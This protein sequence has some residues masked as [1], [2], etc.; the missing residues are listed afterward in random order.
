[1]E[2]KKGIVYSYR[3][4]AGSAP[5][6]FFVTV[7][8][9]PD[10]QNHYMFS[11][12]MKAGHVERTLCESIL[13]RLSID[14]TKL[15]FSVFVFPPKS[16]L[17]YGCLQNLR[18]WLRTAG[19]DHRIFADNDLWVGKDPDFRSIGDASFAVLRNATEDMLIYQGMVG[20]A[21]VS[22]IVRWNLVSVG[23][24]SLS[25]E[26]EAGGAGRPL[27]EDYRLRLDCEPQTVSFMIYSIPVSSTPAG[28][29]HRLRF[30]LRTP[31]TSLSPTSSVNSH[32][33]PTESYIYQRLWKSDSFKLGAG[34][35]F[36]ALGS[37]VVIATRDPGPPAIERETQPLSL[38]PNRRPRTIV[39]PGE[40]DVAQSRFS[41]D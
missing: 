6:Q 32:A 41:F 11:L 16:S 38:F 35:N 25:F 33:H 17:P 39:D 20:Q 30:W 36:E 18:V 27:F 31:Y 23:L 4:I 9:E 14:P 28:A 15:D 34:L 1:M 13:M 26:Y 5:L 40:D 19:M 22:Y 24:Y 7:E 29:S 2:P 8:A 21:H 3:M 10:R 37:K 12:S